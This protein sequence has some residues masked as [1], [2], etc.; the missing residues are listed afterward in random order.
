M[1]YSLPLRAT[2]S[3]WPLMRKRSLR[4][5]SVPVLTIGAASR[6][7]YFFS[8]YGTSPSGATAS[9][10][11]RLARSNASAWTGPTANKASIAATSRTARRAVQD[12]RNKDV[13]GMRMLCGPVIIEIEPV[14]GCIL[15]VALQAGHVALQR[16]R[17]GV[18]RRRTRHLVGLRGGLEIGRASCRE[19]V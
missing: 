19:R 10:C 1:R 17:L 12:V 13:R 7:E 18:A 6:L 14:V 8:V 3:S 2:V 9:S 15:R 11:I 4:G 5:A 16:L